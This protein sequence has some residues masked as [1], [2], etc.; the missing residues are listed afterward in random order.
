MYKH[1]SVWTAHSANFNVPAVHTPTFP[2]VLFHFR[3]GD[4]TGLDMDPLQ[5]PPPL[6]HF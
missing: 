5:S 6:P 3:E 4:W 2:G 1:P